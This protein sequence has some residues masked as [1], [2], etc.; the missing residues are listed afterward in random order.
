LLP[1]L[2]VSNQQAAV[3]FARV[4]EH[5][6]GYGHVKARHLAAARVQWAELLERYHHA[7]PAHQT[8]AA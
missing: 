4:P 8:L 7:A 5:I 3:A 6:R 1:T 2:S